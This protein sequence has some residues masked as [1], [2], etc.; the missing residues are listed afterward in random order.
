[1]D[2]V[3]VAHDDSVDRRVIPR[4]DTVE[5]KSVL[6]VREGRSHFRGEELGCDL[7]N[8][9]AQHTTV[10]YRAFLAAKPCVTPQK[11]RS[12]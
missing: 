3:L 2:S 9:G 12:V 4:A 8:H 1:M 11:S 5:A 6:V 10:L 7:P